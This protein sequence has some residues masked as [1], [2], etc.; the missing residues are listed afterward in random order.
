MQALKKILAVV[1]AVL[2][3]SSLA[4]LNASASDEVTITATVGDSV[5]WRAYFTKPDG[6]ITW[7]PH[8]WDY[9]DAGY[10]KMSGEYVIKCVK[11][12]CAIFTVAF[13][14]PKGGGFFLCP[15]ERNGV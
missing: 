13:G 2:V 6:F 10:A 8:V 9:D 15:D 3:L 5:D 14:D 12:G 1:L 11:P 7:N 4:V